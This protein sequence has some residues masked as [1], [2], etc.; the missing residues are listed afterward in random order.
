[1]RLRHFNTFLRPLL[2]LFVALSSFVALSDGNCYLTQ[3]PNGQYVITCEGDGILVN[4]VE[5]TNDVYIIENCEQLKQNLASAV[6]YISS[7]LVLAYPQLI[8]I[9]NSAEIIYYSSSSDQ[10][11]IRNNSQSIQVQSMELYNRL[12]SVDRSL[13]SEDS[14]SLLSQINS[15]VC[16]SCSTNG[17]GSCCDVDL[18]PILQQLNESQFVLNSITNLLGFYVGGT[19]NPFARMNWSNTTGKFTFGSS[20]QLLANNYNQRN[21]INLL[22]LMQNNLVNTQASINNY[23]RYFASVQIPNISTNLEF[24]LISSTNHFSFFRDLT[25]QDSPLID[26]SQQSGFDNYYDFL[27]NHYVK[28]SFKQYNDLLGDEASK[29]NWFSRIETLL[30]ALVF[31]DAQS[32]NTVDESYGETQQE[33]IINS[34][35]GLTSTPSTQVDLMSQTSD[36]IIASLRSL[37][38]SFS[39]ASSMPGTV[40]LVSISGGMRSAGNSNVI[41]FESSDIRN[42]VEACR[43]AT[44]LGWCFGGLWLL[45]LFISWSVKTSYNLCIFCWD[46]VTAIFGGGGKI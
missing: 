8:S 44:T 4:Y 26:Y 23:L 41:S 1:M 18:T 33:D 13:V 14:S 15:I 45:F 38:S 19:A 16:G 43:C 22:S 6:N 7:E 32:T 31:S 40:E 5:I 20:N 34:L 29:T 21:V 3:Y 9:S 28:V 27:T 36:G 12:Q 24:L 11:D 37:N 10:V 30:A 46:V 42:L 25:F 17:D 39:F 35:D 2:L